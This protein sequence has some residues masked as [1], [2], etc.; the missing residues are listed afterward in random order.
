M[1]TTLQIC[2]VVAELVALVVVVFVWR[3]RD[4][5]WPSKLLRTFVLLI[6]VLGLLFYSFAIVTPD[7][8]NI[9]SNGDGWQP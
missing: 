8:H 1:S 9:N 5:R 7:A 2:F 4:I 6:P 3:R